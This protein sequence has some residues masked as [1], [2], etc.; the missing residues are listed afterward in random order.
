M[1]V[2]CQA[3]CVAGRQSKA[4]AAD[5]QLALR[6]AFLRAG[7]PDRL[8]VDHDSV[9][10]D[11]SPAPFPTRLHLWLQALG[12]D[13]VFGRFGQ[14]TDQ[15][16]VERMHQS[17]TQLSLAG[18]TC[19]TRLRLQ[20]RLDQVLAFVISY[21][22]L[23]RLADQPPLVAYPAAAHP[24]RWYRPEGEVHLL[25]LARVH[26]YLAQGRWFRVVGAN[27][28][29]SLGDHR[30]QVGKD[31]AQQQ[32]EILFRCADQQFVV[33]TAAGEPIQVLP[34]KG[35][36]A[37][38]LMGEAAPILT[39]PAMQLAL[40]FTPADWRQLQLATWPGGTDSCASTRG[41]I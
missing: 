36:T 9:Y 7:L 25:D 22:P 20:D 41:T 40:P 21:L 35:L 10:Y 15:A 32:V 30:Y 24:R 26:A 16:Q 8:A 1:K 31:W 37:R 5:H 29:L 6:R 34:P 4:T 3:V 13:L 33:Q 14:A 28:W 19:A 17:M 39:L 18:P 12:V 23:H 38:D 27:G 2:A 11:R